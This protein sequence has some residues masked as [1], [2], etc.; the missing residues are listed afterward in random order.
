MLHL[1]HY[2]KHWY[3]HKF[4][5]INIKILTYILSFRSKNND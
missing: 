2:G 3:S 5:S 4:G 1:I